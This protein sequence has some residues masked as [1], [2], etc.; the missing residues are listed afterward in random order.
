MSCPDLQINDTESSHGSDY[1]SLFTAEQ[2]RLYEC[3]FK[4]GY[5]LEDPGYEVWLRINHPAETSSDCCH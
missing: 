3:R 4:E 1:S 2:E 5:D